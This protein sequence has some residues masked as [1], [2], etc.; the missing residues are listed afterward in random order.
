MN[1][2][3]LL[4]VKSIKGIGAGL[5]RSGFIE[6]GFKQDTSKM[7][8]KEALL[9]LFGLCFYLSLSVLTGFL[10]GDL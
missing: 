3:Y 7:D 6:A 9:V 10:Y 8:R 4:L 2:V 1:Q 5:A